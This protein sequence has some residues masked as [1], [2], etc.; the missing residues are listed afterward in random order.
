MFSAIRPT[1]SY[2]L[3]TPLQ[4]KF[5]MAYTND[6]IQ[7]A[8]IHKIRMEDTPEYRRMW[9]LYEVLKQPDTADSNI[10][11]QIINEG[12]TPSNCAKHL[13]AFNLFKP[14]IQK[15]L[16][17]LASTATFKFDAPV[18]VATGGLSVD[19]AVKLDKDFGKQY[20]AHLN[21]NT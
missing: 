3:K 4:P 5:S 2:T 12:I 10:N 16:T 18:A 14:E 11:P 7:D 1:T 17:R 20:R 6:D 19:E 8:V 21:E 13:A 15:E 9:G